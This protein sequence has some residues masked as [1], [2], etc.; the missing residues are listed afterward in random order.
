MNKVFTCIVCPNGCDIEA[1]MHG[2]D[3]AAVEGALCPRGRE[4]VEQEVRDPRRTIASSVLVEGGE[5]PLVSVRLSAAIPKARIFEVME[6]IRGLRVAAPVALG[7]VLLPDVLGLGC[8]IV[9]TGNVCR[10]P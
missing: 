10:H 9:A 1:E 6:K 7:D 5:T 3:I 2:M 4:Y 8:D